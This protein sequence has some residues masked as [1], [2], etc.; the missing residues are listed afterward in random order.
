MSGRAGAGIALF[1]AA[2]GAA[3]AAPAPTAAHPRATAVSP[4][5]TVYGYPALLRGPG[6]T[7]VLLTETGLAYG[8]AAERLVVTRGRRGELA[9]ASAD[10][11]AT[12][13]SPWRE[14]VIGTLADVV[15]S[16]LPLSVA[17]PST[18]LD[19]AWI[20]PGRAAWSWWSEGTVVGQT[21][22]A[23]TCASPPRT[24]SST[25]CSTTVGRRAGCRRWPPRRRARTYA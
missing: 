20:R 7:Q 5:K 17:R 14:A 23:S 13:R 6:G 1:A 19:T 16:D 11:A 4:R 15:A 2:V 3:F 8:Q 22:S 12:P 24:G 21:G 9:T 18:L 10:R 25:C